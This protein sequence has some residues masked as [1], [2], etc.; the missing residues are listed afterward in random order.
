MPLWIDALCINKHDLDEKAP[1][2]KMMATI[3]SRAFAVHIWL[4][5]ARIRRPWTS[6]DVFVGCSSVAKHLTNLDPNASVQEMFEWSAKISDEDLER[7]YELLRRPWWQ[8]L[9]VRQE[10]VL[11]RAAAFIRGS[12][13]LSSSDFF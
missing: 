5:K 8:R 6:F 7:F 2:I 12:S 4:G 9:W 3:Y 10:L 13:Y 1:Q 11:G